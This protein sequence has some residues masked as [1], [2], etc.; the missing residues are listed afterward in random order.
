MEMGEEAKD[1]GHK[2]K[3]KIEGLAVWIVTSRPS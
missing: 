1:K 3:V 2:R